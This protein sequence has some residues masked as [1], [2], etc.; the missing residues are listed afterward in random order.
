MR[1]IQMLKINFQKFD[2]N[3]QK[4]KKEVSSYDQSGLAQVVRYV[5]NHYPTSMVDFDSFSYQDVLDALE[6]LLNVPCDDGIYEPDTP[7]QIDKYNP[8][9][10]NMIVE[11]A[12]AN[13]HRTKHKIYESDDDFI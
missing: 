4:Y 8:W 7:D 12:C 9:L 1:G 11:N 5:W 3:L 10:H 6:A 13:L 2:S